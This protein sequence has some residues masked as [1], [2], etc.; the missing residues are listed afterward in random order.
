MSAERGDED[1]FDDVFDDATRLSARRTAPDDD[2]TRLASRRGGPD[3]PDDVD[4]ATRLA[5]RRAALT[6]E[7]GAADAGEPAG[8]TGPS[9]SADET[10]RAAGR[11]ARTRRRPML[12]PGAPATD[13]PRQGDFGAEHDRYETRPTPVVPP[14]TQPA[15]ASAVPSEAVRAVLTPDE[16]AAKRERARRKRLAGIAI[17]VA[18]GAALVTAVV[19]VALTVLQGAA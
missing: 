3:A 19:V 15:T 13:L 17:A 8:D 14:P 16:V 10:T 18:A 4:E 9:S 7:S 6:P 12:P 11:G 2:A 5:S 1:I